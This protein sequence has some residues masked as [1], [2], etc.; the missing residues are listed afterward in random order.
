MKIT[1]IEQSA[2]ERQMEVVVDAKRVEGAFQRAFKKNLKDFT[3][4]GFR[5]GKVPASM[6]SRYIT[7][8][9]LVRDVIQDIVPKAFEEATK[10]QNLQPISQPEWDLVQNERGKDLIFKASFQVSPILKIADYDGLAV[11]QEKEEITDEHIQDTLD[12]MRE[13]HAYFE[14]LDGERGI[15]EGDW[16]TV[17]YTSSQ[18]GEEIEGGSVKNYLMEMKNEN[19]I[20][21]FV[22]NLVGLKPGDQKSFDISFPEDYNNE[23]LAGEAV[24]FHFVIHDIKQKKLPELDDDFAASHSEK[25]TI[26]ELKESVR[27]KLEDG[28]KRQADGQVVTQIV[29]ALLEQ[30]TEDSI[31]VQ[32]RQQHSQRAIRGRMY[33]M[34]QRGIS[35]EQILAARGISQ[36]EWIKEMMGMGL[37]EARLEVLYRS[38]AHAEKVTVSPKEVDDV[39]AAEAPSHKLKPKQLKAQMQKNGSIEMLEYNLLMDK[40]QKMLLEKAKVTY[41][42]PG[43]APA[44]EPKPKKAKAKKS[45]DEDVSEPA[46]EANDDEVEDTSPKKPAAKAKKAGDEAE[47]AEAKKPAKKKAAA[48]AAE[49]EAEETDSEGAEKAKKAKATKKASKTSSKSKD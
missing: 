35:L 32:L 13:N 8:T 17:D 31:P 27:V 41:V 9:G 3:L 48:K 5:R 44:E 46:S 30:V 14:N 18:N 36:E 38:I 26:A 21:G 2:S 23:Q 19:Y 10:E 37:F 6:A 24:T 15:Q 22:D 42:K 45:A 47:V 34:A 29:K 20:I 12:K 4:P 49:A 1:V 25:D 28:V 16:V 7:D 11:T 33:E 39:I 43:E 40:I